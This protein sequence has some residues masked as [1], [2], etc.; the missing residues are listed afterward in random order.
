MIVDL[1]CVLVLLFYDREYVR[2]KGLK[3]E[4]FRAIKDIWRALWWKFLD[5]S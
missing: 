5:T 3:K 4:D 1:R 2:E